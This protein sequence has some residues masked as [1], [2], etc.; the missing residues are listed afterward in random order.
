MRKEG[1]GGSVFLKTSAVPLSS[2]AYSPSTGGT[3]GQAS[4]GRGYWH[5]GH[6]RHGRKALSEEL[7]GGLMWGC[8]RAED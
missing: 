2:L 4:S 7:S 5:L 8:L 6:M 3:P 1:I